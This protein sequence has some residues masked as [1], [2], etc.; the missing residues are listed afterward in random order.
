[1]MGASNPHPH[2]QGSGRGAEPIPQY[3]RLEQTHEFPLFF[4]FRNPPSASPP[5]ADVRNSKGARVYCATIA[6]EIRSQQFAFFVLVAKT[7]HFLAVVVPFG[8]VLAR[9]KP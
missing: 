7:E 4:P 1:M 5:T 8:A 9:S 6:L 3:S 2:C